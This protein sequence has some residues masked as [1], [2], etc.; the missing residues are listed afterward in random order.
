MESLCSCRC[1]TEF[2]QYIGSD[3]IVSISIII[4]FFPFWNNFCTIKLGAYEERRQLIIQ[5]LWNEIHLRDWFFSSSNDDMQ[6]EILTLVKLSKMIIVSQNLLQ[7]GRPDSFHF[8]F[9]PSPLAFLGRSIK[10]ESV[11]ILSGMKYRTWIL[12]EEDKRLE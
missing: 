9:T 1:M 7:L 11:T 6:S 4:L 2:V 8:F 3:E 12:N 5:V 10:F